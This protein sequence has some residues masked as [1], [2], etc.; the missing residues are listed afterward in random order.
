M[1]QRVAQKVASSPQAQ[2]AYMAAAEAFRLISDLS[3]PRENAITVAENGRLG[4]ALATL[5]LE[6]IK[7][8]SGA[9][10]GWNSALPYESAD[11][12]P[13]R[14]Q[15]M[16]DGQPLPR[17]AD[18]ATF[19]APEWV[20]YQDAADRRAHARLY[21]ERGAPSDV[22]LGP[23]APMRVSPGQNATLLATDEADSLLMLD[24]ARP[25]PVALPAPVRTGEHVIESWQAVKSAG[26]LWFA[27]VE[28]GRLHVWSTPAT[29]ATSWIER[30]PPPLQDAPIGGVALV[31]VPEPDANT[32]TTVTVERG[33]VDRDSFERGVTAYVLRHGARGFS[34]EQ[35]A[36]ARPTEPLAPSQNAPQ[37]PTQ[38]PTD[39]AAARALAPALHEPLRR[40]T[41]IAETRV[42]PRA[43]VRACVSG[44]TAHFAVASDD[45]YAFYRAG[46]DGARSGEIAVARVGAVSGGRFELSCDDRRSLLFVDATG[47][48][49]T[50]LL[51]EGEREPHVLPTPLPGLTV[52]RTTDAAALVQGGVLALVRTPG[53]IRA[54]VSTDA[55]TWRGGALLSQ[56]EPAVAPSAENPDAVTSAGYTLTVSAVATYRERV[57][58]LGVGR[59][60]LVRALRFWSNDGG[61]TWN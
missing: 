8:T 27:Y 2:P 61:F 44:N 39:P 5:A 57:A 58:L 51:Y 24:V 53:S 21:R 7:T 35:W 12:F 1:A 52:P 33:P 34:L 50:I 10:A 31:P 32:T 56:F 41:L 11:L 59:G 4:T 16:P 19:A 55:V 60:S 20:L 43:R 29:G 40:T 46:S 30:V 17:A 22:V 15:P 13:V 26:Q 25:L 42:L 9:E 18:G 28:V 3:G 36:L 47:R 54:F 23:G 48:P 37:N 38:N 49:G 6:V 14:T 45:Q